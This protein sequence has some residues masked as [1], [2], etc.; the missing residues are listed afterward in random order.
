[1]IAVVILIISPG[2]SDSALSVAMLSDADHSQVAYFEDFAKVSQYDSLDAIEE[3]V[4]KRDDMVGIVATGGSFEIIM[5]GNE[6]QE[7]EDMAKSIN[8]LY[9]LG[10]QKS[11]SR[12]TIYDFGEHVAPLKKVLASALM[13]MITVM[14]GMIVTMGIVNEKTDDTIKA[15]NVT[16]FKQISY[17]LGKSFMGV[18]MLLFSSVISL[19][20]LGFWDI[21]WLQMLLVLICAS[22]L[23][24]IIA[25]ML[26]IISHDFIEAAGSLKMLF[27]PLAGSI[28]VY[29]LT[30]PKWHWTVWWSPFY[31][32]FKGAD[33]IINRSAEWPSI[34]LYTALVLVITLAVYFILAPKIRKGLN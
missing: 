22:L 5:Q 20:I 7:I 4:G 12:M 18:F 9:E 23:S 14:A 24:I 34:L 2:I 28:L 32:T 10:A 6:S 11:D 17:I 26:G 19:L 33:E 27:L 30:A 29:E 25:F 31:W 8:A 3:R 1:M 21:N 16:P 15:S 13:L